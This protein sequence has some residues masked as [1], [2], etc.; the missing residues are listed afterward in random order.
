MSILEQI[1]KDQVTSRLK[2]DSLKSSLLTTLIGEIER[3]DKSKQSD[4]H[5]LSV[6][7]KM[8]K[9]IDTS[10][11]YKPTEYLTFE[12]NILLEYLPK[13]ATEEEIKAIVDECTGNLGELMK[14]LKSIFGSNFDGKIAK[15][16]FDERVKG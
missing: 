6:I 9:D 10:I 14:S 15:K 4:S 12:K 2:K 1:K 13:Q 7:K 5:T 16:I 8:I 3:V 11:Q